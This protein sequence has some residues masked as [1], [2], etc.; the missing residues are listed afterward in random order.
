[1]KISEAKKIIYNFFKEKVCAAYPEEFPL[2]NGACSK[3]FWD[4]VKQARP[5]KPYIMLSDRDVEKIYNR[6]ESFEKDGRHFVRKEMRLPVTFGVYTVANRGNLVEPDNLAAELA[7][8]IQD[9]LT[10]TQSTFDTLY[11]FGI[12]VNEL[13]VA[14]I[15]DLSGFAQTNQEF[16]KEIDIVFEFDNLEEVKPEFG[17]ALDVEIDLRK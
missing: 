16:R 15:R 1:M 2:Y 4:R 13:E 5:K 12:T 14:N 17:K 6:F 10:E 3:I 11:N 9:L 8:F 7:E